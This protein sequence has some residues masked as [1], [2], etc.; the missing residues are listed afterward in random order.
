MSNYDI[1]TLRF[2]APA[3]ERD[4]NQGLKSYFLESDAYKRLSSR[5]KT[6]VLGNRGSGKSALFKILA[7]RERSRG[8]VVIELSPETYSYE[9][10]STQLAK[11]KEGAWK[12]SGAFAAA[13]KFLTYVLLMK[14]LVAQGH[15]FKSGAGAKVYNWLRDNFKGQQPNP[16]AILVSYLKRLEG[17]KIGPYEAAIKTRQLTSLYHLEE[18]DDLIPCVEELTK[19]KE[20]CVFIDELDRG[21]DAS[22]DAKAFVAGLVQAGF[23]IN[24]RHQRVKV[25]ISLRR[26]LYDN[27]PSLYEDAQKYRDVIETV[28][29]DESALLA[30]IAKRI[31]HTVP[32]LKDKSDEGCWNVIFAEVLQ[33]RSSKSFNYLVDRTLYRPRELIE[34]CT[35]ALDEARRS[36]LLP[37]DYTVV[38]KCEVSYSAERAK[39]IVAEYRFQ[40]PALNSVF[41]SFRGRKYSM[42]RAELEAHCLSICMGEIS[43][44]KAARWASD[45]DPEFIIEVLWRVGFLRAQ[46][47]GGVK[48]LRRSGSQYLGSHQ[49]DNLNLGTIQRFAVHQMFRAGLGMKEPKDTGED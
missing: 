11:E 23:A 12:K 10:L 31:R 42:T 18:L 19:K 15:S 20:V 27:I 17:F 48:A 6:L 25:Y 22:E 28:I 43:I 5:Q 36:S 9:I 3:A 4:I 38:S 46:A 30:M 34:F 35:Q 7:D 24:D 21:W 29:W 8:T 39:D 1:E 32:V 44:D 14:E 40:Y 37:I 45:Q 41:E 47:V 16:I 33:Y 2:G 26:E 13:W 49:I